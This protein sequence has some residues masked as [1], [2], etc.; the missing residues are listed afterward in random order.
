MPD[1]KEI[2][3]RFDQLKVERAVWENT[4]QEVADN[5]LGRRD[6]STQYLQGGRQRLGNIYD[7][8]GMRSAQLFGSA[9]SSLL[10]NPATKWFN[11]TFADPRIREERDYMLWLQDAEEHLRFAFSRPE[12]AFQPQIHESYT[13]LIG[14]G[15]GA[16]AVLEDVVEGV[17]FVSR[18]LNEIYLDEDSRGRVD[19]VYRHFELTARQVEQEYPG[20]CDKAKRAIEAGQP[21]EKFRIINAIYPNR[22]R[23]GNSVGYTSLPVASLHV[24]SGDGPA[25]TLREGGFHEMPILTPRWEKDSGE[26]YGRGPGINALP[27]QKMLNQM[28]KT[29]LK[30][31]QKAVDPPLMV[32]DRGIFSNIRTHAGGMTTVR[33]DGSPN[34]P[35]QAID[36]RAQFNIGIELLKA[37]QEDVEGAFHADILAIFRQPHMTAT[38]VIE[39]ANQVQRILAPVLGRQQNELLEPMVSRV[40][41]IEFRAGRLPPPPAGLENAIVKVEYQSPVARAQQASEKQALF[42]ALGSVITLAQANPD[43][44]DNFDLDVAS[45]HIWEL[46]GLPA[47]VVRD[48][49]EVE[50]IRK[51]RQQ[52]MAAQQAFAMSMQMAEAQAKAGPAKQPVAE[53]A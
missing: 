28:S 6:F 51:Q 25:I 21:N 45:R 37:R 29:L 16:L 49:R 17:Y 7:G 15:T 52:Q 38:Q 40:F 43:V 5:L 34:P 3:S 31:G 46:G 19:T 1:A 11:L 27:D 39:I 18:N 26:T 13:D 33:F 50:A 12:A 30:A 14:F 8:T 36:S 42:E 53:A 32:S 2:R 22:E 35:I 47:Q 24:L 48:L 10:T 23:N 9:V 4:W 20:K 44:L 41:G